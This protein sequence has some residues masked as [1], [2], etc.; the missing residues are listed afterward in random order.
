[1]T[2]T[3]PRRYAGMALLAATASLLLFAPSAHADAPD[4]GCARGFTLWDVDVEPYQADNGQDESGD[5]PNGFVC[6]RPTGD[7]FVYEG[8]THPIYVFFDDDLPASSR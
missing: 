8:E 6:A 3:H 1:M 2:Q 4:D 5:N 7:T